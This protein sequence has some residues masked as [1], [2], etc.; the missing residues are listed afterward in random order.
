MVD[1]GAFIER[2]RDCKC[3]HAD[4]VFVRIEVREEVLKIIEVAKRHK[5]C[6]HADCKTHTAE[7][8]P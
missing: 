2:R 7:E 5:T 1:H 6:P 8:T 3:G 4:K